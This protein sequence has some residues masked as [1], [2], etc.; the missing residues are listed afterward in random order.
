MK[1]HGTTPKIGYLDKENMYA[2][3]RACTKRKF[4]NFRQKCC[5]RKQAP[6]EELFLHDAM[7]VE[8]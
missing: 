3:T 6:V 7:F 4:M 1:E 8:N 2:F 5:S